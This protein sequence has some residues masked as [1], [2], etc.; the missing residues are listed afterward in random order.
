MS[1][2]SRKGKVGSALKVGALL[3]GAASVGVAAAGQVAAWRRDRHGKPTADHI[4]DVTSEHAQRILDTATSETDIK[5]NPEQ[6]Q[7]IPGVDDT[8]R[9]HV[10][11]RGFDVVF[12]ACA[13]VACFIPTLIICGLI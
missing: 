6:K 10:L 12:S 3:F 13:S 4:V 1:Q 9:Y 2:K 7:P 5:L 8:Y 11:K